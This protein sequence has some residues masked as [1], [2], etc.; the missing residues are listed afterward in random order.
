MCTPIDLDVE[1]T[2]RS[3]L[4]LHA[5]AMVFGARV[6]PEVQSLIRGGSAMDPF[7]PVLFYRDHAV[8]CSAVNQEGEFVGKAPD[9]LLTMSTTTIDASGGCLPI[10]IC[11]MPC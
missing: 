1:V 6:R 3:C 2:V 5:E 7:F 9:P 4:S 11:V 8:W 10:S